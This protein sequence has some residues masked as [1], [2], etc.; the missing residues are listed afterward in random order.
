MKHLDELTKADIKNIKI[1]CFDVDG[2]TIKKGTEISEKGTELKIKT[3]PLE[4]HILEK[5]IR[6]AGIY[7][8]RKLLRVR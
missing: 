8:I 1:V 6:K 3:S 2:V 5:M 7:F 4:D